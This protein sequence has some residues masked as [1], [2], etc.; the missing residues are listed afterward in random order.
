MFLI[1][2]CFLTQKSLTCT[3]TLFSAAKPLFEQIKLQVHL[4]CVQSIKFL[5]EYYIFP[6]F[7]DFK[8]WEVLNCTWKKKN[9]STTFCSIWKVFTSGNVITTQSSQHSTCSGP[10]VCQGQIEK[11]CS[12]DVT[13]ELFHFRF[14][15]RAKVIT[16]TVSC[17]CCNPR[18]SR[19]QEYKGA[20]FKVCGD[21]AISA[22]VL[23]QS[24]NRKT[25]SGNWAAKGF[26]AE[27]CEGKEGWNE[28]TWNYGT[29]IYLSMLK[30]CLFIPQSTLLISFNTKKDLLPWL[31]SQKA[32]TNNN[33]KKQ[34]SK[35]WGIN[36][37][38]QTSGC[39]RLWKVWPAAGIDLLCVSRGCLKIND[40]SLRICRLFWFKLVAFTQNYVHHHTPDRDLFQR[41][42]S[43]KT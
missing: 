42:S 9:S 12:D 38:L 16:R 24:Q 15:N 14:W 27:S 21:C 31:F 13:N 8:L 32:Q 39:H 1:L 37:L 4:W 34:F 40:R 35:M 36:V 10:G 17:S 11:Q 5:L 3:H 28:T 20:N 18:C 25:L 23:S 43:H 33:V 29:L 30:K 6:R 41:V 26:L 19:C 2:N 7:Q 22:T